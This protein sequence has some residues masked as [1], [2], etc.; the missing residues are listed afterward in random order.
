[1]HLLQ[2]FFLLNNL[3]NVQSGIDSILRRA[4]IKE[5]MRTFKN[6]FSIKHFST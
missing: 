5:I 1:M 6:I 2:P 4:I 3:N